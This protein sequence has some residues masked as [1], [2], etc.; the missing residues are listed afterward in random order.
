MISGG[1]HYQDKTVDYEVLSVARNAP[2]WM[3]MLQEHGFIETGAA[4]QDSRARRKPST[5]RRQV[6]TA[7][8]RAGPSSTLKRFE[9]EQISVYLGMTH[10]LAA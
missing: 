3:K 9:Q 7:L 8:A 6:K 1:T 2:R 5:G 10:R 4:A